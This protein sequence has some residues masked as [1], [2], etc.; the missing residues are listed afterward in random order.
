MVVVCLPDLLC[1][2]KRTS[3]VSYDAQ[4]NSG[5]SSA[6]RTLL[7]PPKRTRQGKSPRSSAGPQFVP[8][9]PPRKS[10]QEESSPSIVPAP[11]AASRPSSYATAYARFCGQELSAAIP[12]HSIG[13]KSLVSPVIRRLPRSNPMVVF[14]TMSSS[15]ASRSSD[16]PAVL[17]LYKLGKIYRSMVLNLV[18]RCM[19]DR[20]LLML[21]SQVAVRNSSVHSFAS[22]LSSLAACQPLPAAAA[23][24]NTNGKR[25]F[26][27]AKAY[28]R[29]VQRLV[30]ANIESRQRL[31]TVASH[32]GHSTADSLFSGL[33]M[34]MMRPGF[35]AGQAFKLFKHAKTY[36]S[37]VLDMVGS[38]F[39]ERH[40]LFRSS[41][42]AA[43]RE[44]TFSMLL[45]SLGTMLTIPAMTTFRELGARKLFCATK[46]YRAGVTATIV[47]ALGSRSAAF[48]LA[49]N[50]PAA[51]TPLAGLRGMFGRGG[52]TA[53]QA[54]QLY[55]R[56]QAHRC[57]LLDIVSHHFMATEKALAASM[58]AIHQAAQEPSLRHLFTS[59][60]STCPIPATLALRDPTAGALFRAVKDY[61]RG[62]LGLVTAWQER[63]ASTYRAAVSTASSGAAAAL[64]TVTPDN[65]AAMV[66]LQRAVMRHRTSMLSC[67]MDGFE[68]RSSIFA[69][70]AVESHY[71]A[72]TS[73][74]SLCSSFVASCPILSSSFRDPA[75]QKLFVLSK[76][77]KR[78][79]MMLIDDFS[80]KKT[81][82][83]AVAL[84]QF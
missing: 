46:A 62:V 70:C 77:Y 84:N 12:D 35:E 65:Q 7:K 6:S 61:K 59:L 49:A 64:R 20:K 43:R 36:R 82:L 15:I 21:G 56:V 72:V 4:G 32:Q 16:A 75:T 80:I 67:L 24:R 8:R 9:P 48:D 14:G 28:K 2:S 68:A 73:L 13:R 23:F 63:H 1:G 47:A 41:T 60:K 37:S 39:D 5:N 54:V 33:Q 44:A 42:V 11:P 66:Q 31:F 58:I 78:A 45:C 79:V 22:L 25:L 76:A 71:A 81:Q 52:A 55:K 29:C 30:T 10:Q 57:V 83:K 3:F 27:A 53:G 17:R 34:I 69:R 50:P 38:A 18:G 40:L 74:G 19:H 51:A 26:G